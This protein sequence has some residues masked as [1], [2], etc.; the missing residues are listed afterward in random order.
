ALVIL[1]QEGLLER[2]QRKGTFV[3]QTGNRLSTV[4]VYSSSAIWN[5]DI[6]E[7]DF[8]RRVYR[9]FQDILKENNV[10][11]E[12][13]FDTRPVS[14]QTSPWPAL[15][16]AAAEHKIQ[17]LFALS[18]A[19]RHLKW[20]PQLP[21]PAAGLGSLLP[22]HVEYDLNQFV[23]SGIQSLAAKGCRSVG[24]ICTMEKKNTEHFYR[25]FNSAISEA[26]LE[27]RKEWIRSPSEYVRN[28][29]RYG[30]EQFRLLWKQPNR[31]DGVLVFT[32]NTARGV[33]TAV[34]Q[35]KV[36]V[37]EDLHLALHR[38]RELEYICPF[39]ATFL[40]SS[41]RLVAEKYWEQLQSQL[42]GEQPKPVNLKYSQI[43][44]KTA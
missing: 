3:R 24:L 33:V 5:F 13:F 8:A 35:E 1:T 16:T 28:Q 9:D 40:E 10:R 41:C 21:L 30:Y 18:A 38:N 39:P 14:E 31:P 34:L 20:L 25:H 29:E 7:L 23:D 37:P 12:F 42:L 43:E 11:E 26:R 22:S 27:L 32:D 44:N 36:K 15:E 2:L 6:K 17:A 4:G 19:V